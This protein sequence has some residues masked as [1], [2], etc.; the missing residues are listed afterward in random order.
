MA[1]EEPSNNPMAE[2]GVTMRSDSEQYSGAEELSTSPPSSN[3]PPIILYRPPTVWSLMRGA[4]I[5]LFLPFINGM[6]LG[7][8]ELFAHEVAFRLGWGGTRVRFFSV[9]H[10]SFP[11]SSLLHVVLCLTMLLFRFNSLRRNKN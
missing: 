1:S 5:N 10:D 9:T 4:A 2:S 6:M 11:V 3:S 8:G 7:F